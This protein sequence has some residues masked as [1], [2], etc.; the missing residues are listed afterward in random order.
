MSNPL[1]T[2]V[3]YT[4]LLLNNEETGIG[5]APP[6]GSGFD[7]PANKTRGKLELFVAGVVVETKSDSVKSCPTGSITGEVTDNNNNPLGNVVVT[8]LDVNGNTVAATSTMPNGI[9][10]LSDVPAGAYSLTF[11]LTDYNS[12]TIS[13]TVTANETTTVPTVVLTPIS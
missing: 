1:T 10:Y 3:N 2:P 7:T 4:W 9:Y 6:G 13:V 5:L 11:S 12:A 8:V